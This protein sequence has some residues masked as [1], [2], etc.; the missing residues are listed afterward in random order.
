M[1][2]Q[3]R[4]AQMSKQFFLA[5]AAVLSLSGS[6]AAKSISAEQAAQFKVGTATQADVTGALGRPATTAVNSDGTT[7]ITYMTTKTT[8]KAVTFVPIVGDVPRNVEKDG[9]GVA[10]LEPVGSGC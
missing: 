2:G 4:G 6:A 5:M 7:Q 1:I 9:V 3:Q 10:R 8:V